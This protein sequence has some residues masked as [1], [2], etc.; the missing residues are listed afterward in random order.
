MILDYNYYA[1]NRQGVA[2]LLPSRAAAAK[3]VLRG[4]KVWAELLARPKWD[5]APL[6]A[7]VTS[8]HIEEMRD[9]HLA[10]W[11]HHQTKLVKR[12]FYSNLPS[13]YRCSCGL[14]IDNESARTTM[15]GVGW[16]RHV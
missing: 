13:H 5:K 9:L 16:V 6:G 4:Q 1:R 11:P 2:Y 8:Q 14:V 15:L 12:P 3:A 7:W 10:Y